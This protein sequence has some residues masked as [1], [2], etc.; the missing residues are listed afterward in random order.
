MPRAGWR[1]GQAEVPEALQPLP[2]PGTR[3]WAPTLSPAAA[4]RDGWCGSAAADVPSVHL[5]GAPRPPGSRRGGRQQGRH[6]CRQPAPFPGVPPVTC[7]T[8]LIIFFRWRGKD[9][10]QEAELAIQTPASHLPLSF[11]QLR[12]LLA[13]AEGF[14]GFYPLLA[15][16]SL[17]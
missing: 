17:V 15:V 6:R 13:G 10:G 8:L 14:P 4:V 5:P 9:Q 3:R 16:S 2:A 1:G 11:W 12:G 7:A